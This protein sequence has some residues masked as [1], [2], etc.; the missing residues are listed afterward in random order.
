MSLTP[1]DDVIKWKH[2]PRYWPFVREI[3][4]SPV[5]F[6]HKGQWRWAL[7]VT[8]ICARMKGWVNNREAGDLRRYRVH[9]DV[10]VMVFCKLADVHEYNTRN[11][12]MQH[13]YVSFQATN[14][15]QYQS[16]I[17]NCFIKKRIRDLFLHSNDDLFI[18]FMTCCCIIAPFM[19]M[20][21]H[22][23][24]CM[25]KLQMSEYNCMGI[26]TYKHLYLKVH[27][28]HNIFL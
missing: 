1:Y 25:Y 27:F 23:Y 24:I 20:F 11:A 4:R 7:M 6:P 14:L 8:L 26:C 16:K 10:I 15:E 18:W 21:M 12:S 9:Y 5:N 17:C 19:S 3:H 22:V 28:R 13:I 2:F